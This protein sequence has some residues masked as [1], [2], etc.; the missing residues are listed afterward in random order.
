MIKIFI[1][2]VIIAPYDYTMKV[3]ESFETEDACY[4]QGMV[5]GEK[6]ITDYAARFPFNTH[7]YTLDCVTAWGVIT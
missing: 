4:K 5:I 6:M 7:Y 1:L 3:D 2:Y